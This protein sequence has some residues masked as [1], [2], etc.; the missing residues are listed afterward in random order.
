MEHAEK[1]FGIGGLQVKAP[2]HAAEFFFGGDSGSRFDVTARL[3]GLEKGGGDALDGLHFSSFR[4]CNGGRRGR[5]TRQ[6]T[7]ANGDGLTE[8]HG[9]MLFASG[10]V[11]EPVT[12][13]QIVVREAPLLRTEKECD[14][15]I[16]Q[17]SAEFPG[18]LVQEVQRMLQF[19]I[20][21]RRSADN[22]R[23]IRD[24]FGDVVKF[25]RFRQDF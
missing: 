14:A 19:A 16:Q 5:L 21:D 11:Q 23:A 3:Q 17:V 6:F 20:A 18:R 10:N 13:A 8:I 2:N 7:E 25:F 12:M 22:Q 9:L 4:F 15:P 24:R 1:H